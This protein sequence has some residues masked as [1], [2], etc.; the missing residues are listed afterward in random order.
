MWL[1]LIED[2]RDSGSAAITAFAYWTWIDRLSAM[3]RSVI[4]SRGR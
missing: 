1:A 3:R 4:R 2:H